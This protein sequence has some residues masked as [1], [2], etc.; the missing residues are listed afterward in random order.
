MPLY[1]GPPREVQLVAVKWVA[2]H[3]WDEFKRV[4]D[5]L[6][7]MPAAPLIVDGRRMLDKRRIARYAGIGLGA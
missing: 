2:H 1:F 4:P 5:V 7:R 6:A 3:L